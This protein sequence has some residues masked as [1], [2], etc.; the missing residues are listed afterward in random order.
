MRGYFVLGPATAQL[1]NIMG[2][3]LSN[4]KYLA[5]KEK[6]NLS[7]K[8]KPWTDK[9]NGCCSSMDRMFAGVNSWAENNRV[10]RIE[11]ESA[12]PMFLQ[13][14]GIGIA[15]LYVTPP[16]A[17]Q[18]VV[19]DQGAQYDADDGA[20]CGDDDIPHARYGIGSLVGL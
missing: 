20:A 12:N 4:P 13:V 15:I 7:R 8:L 6:C 19:Q 9:V 17:D 5:F 3:A 10:V 14:V 2:R 18:L 16:A 1:H 11:G